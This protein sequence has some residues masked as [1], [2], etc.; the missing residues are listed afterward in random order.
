MSG[1]ILSVLIGISVYLFVCPLPRISLEAFP[2]F[3]EIKWRP[4]GTR[5]R[6]LANS[7]VLVLLWILHTDLLAGLTLHSSISRAI[8][9]M[10]EH[11]FSFT[12]TALDNQR[13]LIDSFSDDAPEAKNQIF[14]ELMQILKVT[15]FSG[16]SAHTAIKRLIDRVHNEQRNTQL[17]A[18]ELA[19]T[20]ATV[21]VLACLP[22]L[23]MFMSA[24]LGINSMQWL[25]SNPAGWAC[26]LLGSS[27]EI[28]GLFW[29]KLLIRRATVVTG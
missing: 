2:K 16:S 5:T 27:L 25:L 7:D 13:D 23:G 6:G 12:R 1:I 18:S 24:G 3:E 26:L 20:K 10:P 15:N 29:V 28:I 11:L 9:R 4:V 21:L 19:G 22:A 17:V 14:C 8:P